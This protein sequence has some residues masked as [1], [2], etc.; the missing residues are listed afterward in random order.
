MLLGAKGSTVNYEYIIDMLL[1][2]IRR[3]KTAILINHNGLAE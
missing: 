1:I 2:N 3:M